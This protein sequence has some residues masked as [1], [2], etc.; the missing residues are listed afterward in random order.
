MPRPKM[1]GKG[2]CGS[3][4]TAFPKESS[5]KGLGGTLPSKKVPP[6]LVLSIRWM[7]PPATPSRR[8]R[9][10]WSCQNPF[11][12]YAASGFVSRRRSLNGETSM[13]SDRASATSSSFDI[14]SYGSTSLVSRFLRA[15]ASSRRMTIIS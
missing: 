8:P 5:W 6:H 11:F 10:P 13:P 3:A 2:R 15:A 12:S 14:H 1:S 9:R 7:L 4:G